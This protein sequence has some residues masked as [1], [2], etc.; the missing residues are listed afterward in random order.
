[1][2]WLIVVLGL[3]MTGCSTDYRDL[4]GS[5][6]FDG[7][8]TERV[9]TNTYRI[10][11]AGQSFSSPSDK[12]DYTMRKAAQTAQSV[13]GTHFAVVVWGGGS[14]AG[15]SSRE[16]YIRVYTLAPNAAPPTGAVSVQSVLERMG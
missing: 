13:G 4:T 10:S 15:R 5:G 7:T 9:A 2:R 6:M 1:M 8:T 14:E 11:A 16:T 12:H 3:A